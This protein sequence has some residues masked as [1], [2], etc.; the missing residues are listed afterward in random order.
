MSVRL[1]AVGPPLCRWRSQTPG[2]GGRARSTSSCWTL[3]SRTAR[4]VARR[5][6]CSRR[7]PRSPTR[8]AGLRISRP[9][10]C[11][12]LRGSRSYRRARRA[13][14]TSGELVLV[15]GAGGRGHT[16]VWVVPD[17]HR[18]EGAAPVRVARRIPPPRAGAR[19][20][21]NSSQDRKAAAAKHSGLIGVADAKGS[22]DRRPASTA[23]STK[24]S[25]TST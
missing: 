10:R 15:S 12:R 9:S 18:R 11:A 6:Y 17:P 14:L 1:A 19:P 13:L 24:R 22:Q 25:S 3:F 23:P 4:L 16:N 5:G 2:R 7:W 20:L 8:T 21:V